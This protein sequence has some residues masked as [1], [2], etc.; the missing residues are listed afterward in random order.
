MPSGITIDDVY[1]R[2]AWLKDN[3]RTRGQVE[4][5]EEIQK[6]IA[7]GATG[8]EILMSLR[9]QVERMLRNRVF[10]AEEIAVAQAIIAG[11]HGLLKF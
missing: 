1:A 5:A 4:C 8:T 2:A 9:W 7:A 10:E 3:L 6:A 11:I